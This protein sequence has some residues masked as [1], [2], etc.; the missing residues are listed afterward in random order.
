MSL[1]LSRCLPALTAGFGGLGAGNT[2]AGGFS[3]GGF[4]LNANPAA[5]SFNAGCFCAAT[6]AGAAFNFGNSLASTGRWPLWLSTFCVCKKHFFCFCPPSPGTM[7]FFFHLSWWF[8]FI[9]RLT[10]FIAFAWQTVKVFTRLIYEQKLSTFS[11]LCF[12]ETH[13]RW[14]SFNKF[15]CQLTQHFY[16]KMLLFYILYVLLLFFHLFFP[17]FFYQNGHCCCLCFPGTFGGF[18][19]TTTSA[20]APGS[21]F[22]F[23]TPS[24]TTGQYERN[25]HFVGNPD[26][27]GKC[28]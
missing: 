21:T 16:I 13:A 7:I 19:T 5:I 6:T 1:S 27:R 17:H 10:S 4:G 3:F 20:V 9:H 8:L 26:F 24:N 18:G 15:P 2:T 23:A 22:S 11:P 12:T 14:N 28:D 25:L